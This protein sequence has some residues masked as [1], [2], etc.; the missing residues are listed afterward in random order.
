MTEESNVVNSWLPGADPD[1]QSNHN[2]KVSS[3][4]REVMAEAAR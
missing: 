1:E 4:G 2:Y 3:T